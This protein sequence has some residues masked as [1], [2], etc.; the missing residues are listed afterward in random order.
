LLA[1]CHADTYRSSPYFILHILPNL[2]VAEV[3]RPFWFCN[4]NAVCAARA[5]SDG[6]PRPAALT[7]PGPAW[8][9]RVMRP[10]PVAL[11]RSLYAR[12]YERVLSEDAAICQGLQNAVHQIHEAPRPGALE[13][14]I[15]GFEDSPGG[16]GT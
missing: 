12:Y 9:D 2:L 8:T 3:Y 11:R 7:A 1:G 6:V 16:L 10:L 13:Q 15:A 14:R 5:G 4:I